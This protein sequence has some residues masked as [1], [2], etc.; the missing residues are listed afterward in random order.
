MD[1]PFLI[2]VAINLC[3]L[4]GLIIYRM[5]A[6]GAPLARMALPVIELW[7]TFALWIAIFRSLAAVIGAPEGASPI[8]ELSDL[9]WRI[10]RLPVAT[11]SW[12]LGGAGISLALLAHLLW[13]LSKATPRSVTS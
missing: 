13:S 6:H 3:F 11:R 8:A 7:V 12:L 10:A 2:L 5:A 9:G 4:S 1:A